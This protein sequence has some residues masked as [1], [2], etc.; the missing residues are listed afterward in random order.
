MK[1]TRVEQRGNMGVVGRIWQLV[2][3]NINSFVKEA[4]DPE[5]IL[6]TAIE[7]VEKELIVIRRAIAQ[8]I[9][10]QKRTERQIKIS[11]NQAQE[12]YRRAELAINQREEKI[13]EEALLR[14]IPHLEQQSILEKQIQE[15][16]TVLN[17]L[18]LQMRMVEGKLAEMKMQKNLYIARITSAT[19]EQKLQEVTGSLSTTGAAA[20]LEKLETQVLELEEIVK[21]SKDPL[22]RKFN[23]L[24]ANQKLEMELTQIREKNQKIQK[25]LNPQLS[26]RVSIESRKYEEITEIEKLKAEIEKI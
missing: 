12:W 4:E 6:E 9:A 19:A 15:Q 25:K 7:K 17:K 16:E 13:A 3:T 21:L 23:K 22:E 8:A 14:R 11:Q 1:I 2:S 10:L 20:A 18:K 5:K 24:E 26:R